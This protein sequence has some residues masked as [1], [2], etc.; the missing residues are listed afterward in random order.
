MFTQMRYNSTRMNIKDSAT[1]NERVASNGGE[2]L[3]SIFCTYI[4]YTYDDYNICVHSRNE[5]RNHEQ[6]KIN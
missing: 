1:S 4:Y 5:Q 2:L 6:Q 3:T